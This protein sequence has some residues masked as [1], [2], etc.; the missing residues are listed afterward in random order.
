[1]I[2]EINWLN[3]SLKN[4]QYWN[5]CINLLDRFARNIAHRLNFDAVSKCVKL[6]RKV[7]VKRNCHFCGSRKIQR[8]IR[9]S[10]STEFFSKRRKNYTFWRETRA[11]FLELFQTLE[12]SDLLNR[13]GAWKKRCPRWKLNYRTIFIPLKTG[14]PFS[15]F[16]REP[17][18]VRLRLGCPCSGH[19][20]ITSRTVQDRSWF[21]ACD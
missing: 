13:Y 18:C 10:L 2:S 17:T 7:I 12:L 8:L 21:F 14:N 20:A 9:V 15:G 5:H 1:M 11:N 4:L 19:L 3:L 16:R 6:H